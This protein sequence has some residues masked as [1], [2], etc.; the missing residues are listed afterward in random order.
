MLKFSLVIL[1]VSS[2]RL[3]EAQQTNYQ[4]T[5]D[6]ISYMTV[7]VAVGIDTWESF[8]CADKKKCLIRQGIKD[9]SIE[10]ASELIKHF[11]PVNRPCYPDCGISSNNDDVPSGHTALAFGSV[12]QN[13]IG[14]TFTLA[15]G[16]GIGRK[17]ANKHDLKA[18]LIGAGIGSFS[19]WATN[20]WIH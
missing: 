13:R 7:G 19:N 3:V 20:K 2:A 4:K 16:T 18:I 12:N 15:V 1:L 10:L 14:L 17:E 8:H 9:G 6:V 5:A 11:F